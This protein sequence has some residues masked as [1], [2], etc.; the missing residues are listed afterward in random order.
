MSKS[1][2]R[3]PYSKRDKEARREEVYRLYFDCSYSARKI[4]DMMK[5]NRNTVNVD[6]S[7]WYS[8]FVEKAN[9]LDPATTIIATLERLE[10]QYERLRERYDKTDSNQE[11]NAIDR[12][13]LDVN[14]KIIY[15]NHRLAESRIK[16]MNSTT[17]GINDWLKQ[18]RR[19]TRFMT[20]FDRIRVSAESYEKIEE[21]ISADK[22]KGFYY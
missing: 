11:K 2:G 16:I 14:S 4:A 18:E 7:Y 12:L 13:M 1:R 17:E 22:K 15:T 19:E 8:K 6:I 3:G 10:F 9:I 5:V 20:L 21:I